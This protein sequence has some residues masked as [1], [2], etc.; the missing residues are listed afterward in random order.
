M[1]KHAFGVSEQVRHK[2]QKMAEIS[3]LESQGMGLCRL[4]SEHKCAVAAQLICTFVFANAK[5]RFS[6]DAAQLIGH[7][8]RQRNVRSGLKHAPIQQ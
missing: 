5:S 6:R 2:T 4:C 3:D 1:R 7:T 8:M